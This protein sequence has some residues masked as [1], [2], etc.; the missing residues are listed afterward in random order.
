MIPYLIWSPPYA[1]NSAGIKALHNLCKGL[2]RKRHTAYITP[3]YLETMDTRM[4]AIYP[5]IVHGNPFGLKNRVRWILNKP[6]LLCNGP[7]QYDPEELLFIWEKRYLNL[8]KD[9]ILTTYNFDDD[10]FHSTGQTRDID[11]V[12]IGKGIHRRKEINI[13]EAVRITYEW[14]AKRD[15]LAALLQR[16][17]ILYTF[18]DRTGLNWEAFL[19]GCRIILMPENYEL[20]K[21]EIL[22]TTGLL[23]ESPS[24]AR[25]I[26]D[27]QLDN[28]I[29]IT[30]EW[31]E[32]E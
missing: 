2:N 23:H 28:F 13:P 15:E 18:D 5:E 6:G 16:T 7:K 3:V 31:A 11:C 22:K 27:E 4:I 14:P 25:K 9:R 17:N 8:P 32:T 24:I 20:S 29:R 26:C 1:H 10:L 19:C 21:D 12:W 30:Q